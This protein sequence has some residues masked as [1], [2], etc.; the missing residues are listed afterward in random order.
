MSFHMQQG[1]FECEKCEKLYVCFNAMQNPA[2]FGDTS[3]AGG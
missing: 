3:L 1:T 2:D